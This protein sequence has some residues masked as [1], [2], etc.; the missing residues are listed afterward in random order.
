MASVKRRPDGAWRA[1]YRDADGR[2]HARHFLRK[3]DAQRW[4][5]EVTASIVTGQYV[6]PRAGRTT[7]G[8]YYGAWSARQVWESN[9]RA[10][11]DLALR[12]SGLGDFAIAS[13]RRS[14][15]ET[16]VK[17]MSAQG[18]AP[19]TVATRVHNLASVFRAAVRDKVIASSPTE[20]VTLPRA[21]RAAVAMVIPTPE[22]VGRL[23]EVVEPAFR[24]GV[25]LGAF[26]GLRQGEVC[27]AQVGDVAFLQR[28]FQVR[29]QVQWPGGEMEIRLP[30]YGSE[31]TIFIPDSL[32]TD[33]ARRVEQLDGEGE[34]R[35][36][37]PSSRDRDGARPMHRSTQNLYWRKARIAAKTPAY[38]FHSLRHFYASALIAAGCDVVT[39]QRAM[40]HRTASTTLQT[41]AH[42]WP[43]A[44]DRTRA[45]AAGLMAAVGGAADSVR[46][47]GE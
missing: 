30:K 15:I 9:T 36:L 35:W 46:T 38:P 12:S 32:I 11:M 41:Y 25:S 44:E 17:S 1:R 22:E 5:D 16:W 40:G 7:L 45:A 42:L 28:T 37:F 34:A 13:V 20:N 6:D 27:G 10:A 33:L 47:A 18:L 31:R 29:R 2:E 3:V 19:G 21:R 8:S 14:H 23:L 4:L 43:S 24:V 26:A 39:V